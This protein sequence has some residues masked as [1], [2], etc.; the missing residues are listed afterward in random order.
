[1]PVY[2]LKN[3]F[4]LLLLSTSI[5]AEEF[6]TVKSVRFDGNENFSASELLKNMEA[7]PDHWYY[8]LPIFSQPEKISRSTISRDLRR[9]KRFYQSEGYFEATAELVEFKKLPNDQVTV[10]IEINENQPTFIDSVLFTTE[11]GDSSLWREIRRKFCKKSSEKCRY[12]EERI[13]E[14]VQNIRAQL[15]TRGYAFNEV[16]HKINS[17]EGNRVWLNFQIIFGP[18]CRFDSVR[19]E[20]LDRIPLQL[21]KPEIR[22]ENGQ[23]FDLRKIRETQINLYQQ[24][25]FRY[26]NVVPDLSEKKSNIPVTIFLKE[27][28]QTSLRLGTGYGTEENMR[29]MFEL[30]KRNFVGKAR[31][32]TATGK[33]SGLG[34]NAQSNLFQPR[35]LWRSLSLALTG[36]YRF[37]DEISYNAYRYGGTIDFIQKFNSNLT[38]NTNYRIERT[39]LD[40]PA[41]LVAQELQFGQTRY[42]KS[43][44]KWVLKYQKVDQILDPTRGSSRSLSIENSHRITGSAYEFWKVTTDIRFYFP[45]PGEEVVALRVV[46][47]AIETYGA[48]HGV[49]FEERY[50]AGGSNSV[51]GYRRHFLGPVDENNTPT[52]GNLL[53]ESNLELRK[54]ILDPLSL[55]IFYEFGNVWS[56]TEDFELNAL[57]PSLGFGLRVK[58]PVG[59]I[60]LDFAF[61]LR[62]EKKQS[63]YQIHLSVG[64]AF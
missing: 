27:R 61:K 4:I 9:L 33:Y 7:Q 64:Q 37:D 36:F 62:D 54:T 26:V 1:M 29:I 25:L 3:F 40:A 39:V 18:V 45:L 5:F 44:L 6:Y 21:V 55:A 52:G 42:V 34:L 15:L 19:V 53:F 14:I 10:Q 59:P 49:P 50:F 48:R 13:N 16:N 32:L 58:T 38:F 56:E 24:D 60:R 17:R 11:N 8:N 12:R 30:K 46:S 41:E 2:F 35:F 51:R 31:T 47:G 63:A 20:G 43:I 28:K 23:L 22:I 57:R